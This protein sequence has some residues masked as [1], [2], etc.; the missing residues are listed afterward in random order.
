MADKL[1]LKR[2]G[3]LEKSMAGLK[4]VTMVVK[5]AESLDAP[6][7]GLMVDQKADLLAA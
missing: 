6:M 1:G 3:M 7:A 2:V 5:M 4:D